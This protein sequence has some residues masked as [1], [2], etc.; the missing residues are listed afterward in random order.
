MNIA[1]RE[2]GPGQPPYI[3]AEVSCNHGGSLERA[4]EM[5][6]S[7]KACGADAVKFQATTA[8]TITIDCDRP[9]FTVADGPWKG[10]NLYQL[11]KQTE[12]PF[13]WFPAIKANA[14]NAGITWFASVFSK[15]A[16]DL[17]VDLDAPAIKIASFEIVDLPLIRYAASM[18][19]KPLIISTGMASG[20]EI[21]AAAM[22]LEP[23]G[24][25]QHAMLHCVSE[26][27]CRPDQA[28]LLRLKYGIK[29]SFV[30]GISDH[31]TGPEIPIAATALGAAI[32]EKHFRLSW[33]PDTEDSPFSLDE[34]DFNDMVKHVRNTWAAMQPVE[35]DAPAAHR[36]LRRSLFAVADIPAGQPFTAENVRSIR[37]G[38]GFTPAAINLFIGKTA[39]R[40]IARGEPMAWEMVNQPPQHPVAE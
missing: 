32:I 14:E 30:D 2:I 16:V 6:W 24:H 11:Y 21:N 27:P 23:Y 4:L 20:Q 31:S 39:V 13:E 29:Y 37:P 40:D 18:S 1:G 36:P 9:E 28:N 7:A 33:H 38:Y 35:I 22:A 5:I 17:M 34:V 19:G 26:Y 8:D 12:T 15:K 25:D 3:I 10:R